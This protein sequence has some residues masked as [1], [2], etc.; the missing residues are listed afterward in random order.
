M[1]S[2]EWIWSISLSHCLSVHPHTPP[3]THAHTSSLWSAAYGLMFHRRHNGLLG[4]GERFTQ[5]LFVTHCVRVNVCACTL[6]K[7][8]H[9]LFLH[10]LTYSLP[11]E[12]M[13][14]TLFT[15]N[16]VPP[17]PH[18]S[19]F[20]SVYAQERWNDFKLHCILNFA[21]YAEHMKETK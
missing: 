4:G 11:E 16:R 20:T 6:N 13:E 5:F 3:L 2:T 12:K 19:Q 9:M 17:L 10:F 1:I 14:N 8:L 15:R 7:R 18:F 21:L